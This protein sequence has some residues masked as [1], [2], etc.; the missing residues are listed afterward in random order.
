MANELVPIESLCAGNTD[1]GTAMR[2][3]PNELMR[4]YVLIRVM[5][6]K[7]NFGKAAELAGYCA[8]TGNENALR[9]QGH[10]LEHDPR[11]QAAIHEESLRQARH[12]LG[13]M[14]VRASERIGEVLDNPQVKAADTLK[15]ATMIMDRMGLHPISET[16]QTV[17]HIGDSPEVVA[18][19][20]RL[21]ATLGIDAE[22]LLGARLAR[23][24]VVTEAEY[25]E[26]PSPPLNPL[27]EFL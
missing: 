3:L 21:A 11:I 7:P 27:K 17:E 8:E 20:R 23:K 26:L 16:K 9:V 18:K 13:S 25:E 15:A 5:Q 19:V 22:T 12:N 24:P 1:F 4:K 6:G 2:K 10:R 14:L